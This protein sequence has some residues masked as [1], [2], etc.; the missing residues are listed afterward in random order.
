MSERSFWV[1]R[2]PVRNPYWFDGSLAAVG[3]LVVLLIF[4]GTDAGDRWPREPDA[5]GAVLAV[6]AWVP[7]VWRRRTPRASFAVSAAAATASGVIGYP[8]AG[9]SLAALI[10]LYAVAAR[11]DR[12]STL[13]AVV[14]ALAGSFVSMAALGTLTFGDSVFTVVLVAGIAMWG[15]RQ[16]V[17]AAYFEQ[18]E[19]R[20]AEKE[21]ERIEAAQRAVSAERVRIARELHDVVAHA[22]SVVAVQS[23]V[24]AHV[25]DK[26]PAAAKRLL[27]TISD[28][29]R[30]ALAEMRRMLGVLREEDADP[31]DGD[32][33]RDRTGEPALA[34]APGL[35]GL[36]DLVSRVAAAGVPVTLR[37]TGEATP[38]PAGV[39]VAA[40]RIVQEALTNVLKHAGRARATVEVH[41]GS[42]EVRLVIADDGRGA[43]P[44]TL[45]RPSGHG[46]VGMRERAELYGGRVAAGARAG[47]G[48]QVVAI[49]HPPAGAAVPTAAPAPSPAAR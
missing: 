44:R 28:T 3:G 15:N 45:H 31:D 34:P 29:S 30:D 47:G 18:L 25:I 1:R 37:V 20:A 49:L 4:L 6:A 5:L 32:R 7:L 39:D 12:R 8:D 48:F 2:R 24:G 17:R 14:A 27:E 43:D 26:D 21:R 11:C 16:Q 10:L 38:L 41:H 42:D 35:A 40:Y 13:W 19:L 9:T 22:M 46:I 23:G 36:D 33:T